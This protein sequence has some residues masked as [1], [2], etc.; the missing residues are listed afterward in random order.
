[1]K[2]I[3]IVLLSL[4]MLIA[5]TSEGQVAQTD[6]LIV[7]YLDN[8]PFAYTGNEGNLTG[9]E[10]DLIMAFAD[11]MRR[12][13]EVKLSIEFID[14]TDFAKLYERLKSP[15]T[16][17]HIG[18]ASATITAE[19]RKEV[20]FTPPYMKNV[21]LLVSNVDVPTLRAYSD[22]PEY[23]KNMTAL[24]MRSTVLE[25]HLLD[26]QKKHHE[27]MRVSYVEHPVDVVRQ[28]AATNDQY[29]GYV[30]VLTYWAE[31]KREPMNVKIHRIANLDNQRFGLMLP[32]NSP[33]L[34]YWQEFMEAGFGFAATE[35]YYNILSR[36][37]SYEVLE[38]VSLH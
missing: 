35:T 1:M 11:W 34:A 6:K 17:N 19:R 7:H 24:V 2:H 22:M 20:D 3:T 12:T 29:Y 10:V 37:L 5:Q 21:S 23:F 31:L 4:F 25:N 30:D 26:I 13:K 15:S 18:L 9:I 38:T 33:Y 16:G 8:F 27:K 36:H 28:I 14:Y 32:K